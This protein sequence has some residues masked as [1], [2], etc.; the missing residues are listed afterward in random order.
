MNTT[1]LTKLKLVSQNNVCFF[2]YQVE[3]IY[4]N[5]PNILDIYREISPPTIF[6]L[7]RNRKET[8]MLT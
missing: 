4:K 1:K 7:Y 5:T 6:R 3:N 2:T 8:L